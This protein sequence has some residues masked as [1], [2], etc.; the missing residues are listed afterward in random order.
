MRLRAHSGQTQWMPEVLMR[1]ISKD[2]IRGAANAN[3]EP[4]TFWRRVAQLLDK[5][6][7]NRSYRGIPTSALRRSKY[8]LDRCRRMLHNAGSPAVVAVADTRLRR[9]ARA[10]QTRT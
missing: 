4:Q 10:A 8:D 1:V 2:P 5:C 7:V 3:A 9:V 6:V